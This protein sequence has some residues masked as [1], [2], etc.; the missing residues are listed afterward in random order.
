M[1]ADHVMGIIPLLRNTLFPPSTDPQMNAPPLEKAPSIEIYGPA[2][3]RN[4]VRSILKMTLTKTADNYV[5]HELLTPQDQ[6]TLCDPPELLHFNEI[7]GR[8][9]YCSEQDGFWRDITRDQGKFCDVAVDAGPI[10]HRD[11]CLGYVFRECAPLSRKLVFLG[12]AY[13]A[14]SI[15]PL[16]LDPSPSL[17]VH[18]STEA[19]IPETIDPKSKRSYETVKSKALAR[20]HSTPEQAG[21]FAKLV[22]AQQLVLNHIGS[23]FPHPSPTDTKGIRAGVL[24]E[25][26]RQASAAWGMGN[27]RV[28]FDFMRVHVPPPADEFEEGGSSSAS[29]LVE[30]FDD[31]PNARNVYHSGGGR[32]R[33]RG[34]GQSHNYNS[35]NNSYNSGRGKRPYSAVAT[36]H[37]ADSESSRPQWNRRQVEDNDNGASNTYNTRGYSG[38]RSRGSGS[39]GRSRGRGRGRGRGH[40]NYSRSGD[41][42]GAEPSKRRN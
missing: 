11:P 27:A 38:D 1:H 26:E 42:D 12:D 39:G 28:A 4:F 36:Q 32:G 15:V 13:D 5:V 7:P 2:G 41:K 6:P 23:R 8:D 20:G 16:C 3:I 18:E 19:Y 33:G 25:M 29:P 31:F 40:G 37:A 21:E 34:R 10:L 22:G 30:D 9:I 24:R 17:V 35:Y 14:S